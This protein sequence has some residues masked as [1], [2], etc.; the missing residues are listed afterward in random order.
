MQ[1][2]TD[3]SST[4]D[5]WTS[6]KKLCVRISHTDAILYALYRA[7][8]PRGPQISM[9]LAKGD[10][11]GHAFHDAVVPVQ[12][13]VRAAP[14]RPPLAVQ[15]VEKATLTR[16]DYGRVIT[17]DIPMGMMSWGENI[18]RASSPEGNTVVETQLRDEGPAQTH[19]GQP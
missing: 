2:E 17:F 5:S 9:I 4:T 3:S 10:T 14:S 8:D 6:C 11:H 15:V 16:A 7:S 18:T 12:R 13:S 1:G 19:A